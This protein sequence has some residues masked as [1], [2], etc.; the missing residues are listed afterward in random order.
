M[1]ANFSSSFFSSFP[2]L[3]H[4]P[5]YTHITTKVRELLSFYDFDGDEIE[6][7]SGSALAAI[8]ES[9]DEIGKEAILKLMEAVEKSIPTPERETQKPFLMPVEDTFS[10]SGRGTVV[11]GRIET[12]TLRVGDEVEIVGLKKTGK[13][14]FT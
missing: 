5:S 2:S 7:V 12:G 3:P 10:I 14:F 8:T 9:N 1:P 4:T 11:T 6:I 13:D